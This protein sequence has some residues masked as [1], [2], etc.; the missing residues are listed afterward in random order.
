[1]AAQVSDSVGPPMS[2]SFDAS[3]D[4]QGA[5]G[6]VYKAVTVNDNSSPLTHEYW[7]DAN[8]QRRLK[9]YP[10]GEQDEYFYG[11]NSEIL[12]DHENCPSC[13]TNTIDQYVWVGGRPLILLRGS[14]NSAGALNN[15]FSGSCADF[16]KCGVYF[17]VTDY[18]GKPVL[19]LDSSL[20]VAGAADY[21]PFGHVTGWPRLLSALRLRS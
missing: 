19:L 1:M 5:V 20:L 8:G 14:I 13:A 7:Y 2:L 12:E 16:G 15:D 11:I 3:V 4:G 17:P 18:L 10:D 9:V 6:S 21:D